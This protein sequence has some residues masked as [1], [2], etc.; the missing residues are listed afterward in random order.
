MEGY[1][2]VDIADRL[3]CVSPSVRRKL[4]LSRKTWLR[5]KL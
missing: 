3:G 5:D 4:E 2:E 1:S